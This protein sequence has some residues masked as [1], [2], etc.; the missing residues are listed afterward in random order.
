MTSAGAAPDGSAGAS[1][2]PPLQGL[3]VVVTGTLP[4]FS[5]EEAEEAVRQRGGKAT[6]S[7]SRKTAFVVVGDN[8]G[9]KYAKAVELG[10]P[11]LDATGFGVLLAEGPEAARAV[12]R[13]DG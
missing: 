13:G 1:T 2:T 5:R 8:P 10:V 3:T 7:V 9:S 12:A 4:G 11:I 6:G